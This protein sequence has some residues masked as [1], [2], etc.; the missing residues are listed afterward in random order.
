MRIFDIRFNNG[1]KTLLL[2]CEEGIDEYEPSLFSGDN[3]Y[4]ETIDS[5]DFLTPKY[6]SSLQEKSNAERVIIEYNG[7]QHYT[8]VP[9]FHRGGLIDFI[10]QTKRDM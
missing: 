5:I 8:Y 10:N 1:E 3:V 2:V 9:Y 7:M 4:I 6:L